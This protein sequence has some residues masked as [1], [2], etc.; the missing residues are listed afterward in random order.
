MSSYKF[1]V[2]EIR[3]KVEHSKELLRGELSPEE[4]EKI[5]MSLV[6][7]LGLLNST[8]NTK[9]FN[10]LDQIT[11][12]KFS[13]SRFKKYECLTGE[14]SGQYL[15]GSDDYL[16][17]DYLQFLINLSNNIASPYL[18]SPKFNPINISA[19]QMVQVATSFYQSLGDPEILSNYQRIISKPNSITISE[20]VR[21][22]DENFRGICNYDHLYNQP[23]V[24]VHTSNDIYDFYI[25]KNLEKHLYKLMI[26]WNK[27]DG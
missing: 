13:E 23:Y 15:S 21:S 17:D 22:G 5:Q 10:F 1:N 4:K 18:E 14:I 12:G 6:A 11:H 2:K 3:E 9:L 16:D 26:L 25:L 20:D 19:D 27:K 24:T 7:Y 8:S